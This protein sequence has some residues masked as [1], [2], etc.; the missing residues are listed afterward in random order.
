MRIPIIDV[1]K[2]I[3]TETEQTVSGAPTY[4]AGSTVSNN[5]KVTLTATLTNR[6]TRSDSTTITLGCNNASSNDGTQGWGA[7]WTIQVSDAV[8]V[9]SASIASTPLNPDTT[10]ITDYVISSNTSI[11]VTAFSTTKGAQVS[12][13][14][15][16][17]YIS[18]TYASGTA[19]WSCSSP[20]TIDS[21]DYIQGLAPSNVSISGR[22]ITVTLEGPYYGTER[23]TILQVYYSYYSSGYYSGVTRTIDLGE[24]KYVTAVSVVSKSPSGATVT[25]TKTEHGAS[26][27]LYQNSSSI[28]NATIKLEYYYYDT[29]KEAKVK[30]NGT[31]YKHIKYNGEIIV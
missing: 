6:L 11:T 27:Y 24:D 19:S 13:T 25:P 9:I 16:Y 29:V 21:Y 15:R 4:H 10:V 20:Y 12:I 22:T 28:I 17:S 30:H 7:F 26:V 23:S 31:I 8:E 18:S 5:Q 3:E 14:I 1:Q 2:Q